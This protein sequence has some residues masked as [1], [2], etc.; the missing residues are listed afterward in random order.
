MSH[1]QYT[2]QPWTE[3]AQLGT[4]AVQ[5]TQ[6]TG[7]SQ[8]V[9]E[10]Q[11]PGRFV[12]QPSFAATTGDFETQQ[13]RQET[14]QYVGQPA[15]QAQTFAPAQ[16]EPQQVA[17]QEPQQLAQPQVTA[18]QVDV[19]A[20]QRLV[21]PAVSSQLPARS[22]TAQ[23]APFRSDVQFT[24]GIEQPMSQSAQTVP[25][26]RTRGV[27][28]AGGQVPGGVQTASG[29][30]APVRAQPAAGGQ[31]MAAP[32]EAQIEQESEVTSLT[33]GMPAVDIYET[34]DELVIFADVPG[35]TPE[36][37]EL[38]GNESSVTLVAKR[39]EPSI[40]NG[41]SIQRECAEEFERT[42]PLPARADIEEA[43]ASVED[44]VVRTT[45]PKSEDHREKRIG[46][47]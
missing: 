9:Q 29:G 5:S 27:Q 37:V 32:P 1:Y 4:R 10:T 42:I 35:C 7:F 39:G 28:M 26:Q 11:V 43:E 47:Q 16:I 20:G 23:Q 30:Q 24:T 38:L 31:T 33:Q 45:L 14:G 15:Q 19:P 46:I 40:T 17:T 34:P 13:F 18:R 36:D 6:P 22:A 2:Q 8:P 44:G 41:K 25:A 3:R 12:Q 21:Q